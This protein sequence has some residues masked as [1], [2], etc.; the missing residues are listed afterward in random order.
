MVRF[1]NNDPARRGN[2]EKLPAKWSVRGTSVLKSCR[3]LTARLPRCTDAALAQSHNLE[4]G[5]A[6]QQLALRDEPHDQWLVAVSAVPPLDISGE[7]R[8][9]ML[10]N[11]VD[12]FGQVTAPLL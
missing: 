5:G 1:N 11:R 7:R 9:R 6:R 4:H 8:W 12:E 2:S 10:A 3:F